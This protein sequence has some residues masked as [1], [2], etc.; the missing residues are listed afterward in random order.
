MKLSELKKLRKPEEVYG[1]IYG[2]KSPS[3][4]WY[5]GQTKQKTLFSYL[6]KSYLK[7]YG[8]SRI[9]LRNA[10]NKYGFES[11]D[12]FVLDMATD[13]DSLN[14]LEIEYINFYDSICNGYNCKYGGDNYICSERTKNIRRELMKGKKIPLTE[15][16]RKNR[17]ERM[18]YYNTHLPS[19]IVIKK[20]ERM[21]NFN[22]NRIISNNTRS[23]M[24]LGRKG[25]KLIL[26]DDERLRRANLARSI[27]KRCV[28]RILSPNKEEFEVNNLREFCKIHN[29]NRGNL[30]CKL[31][32][33]GWILVHKSDIN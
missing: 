23:K 31:K 27:G 26:S 32:D 33:K 9:K 8:E 13:H 3:G 6:R 25:K 17:S 19:D 21:K 14:K 12:I 29:L 2:L 20:S 5:I 24:S 11:L 1:Y 22:S 4:K 7:L 18:I 16:E 15:E 28:Y 30:N 10:I